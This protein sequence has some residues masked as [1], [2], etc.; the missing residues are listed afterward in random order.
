MPNLKERYAAQ[1]YV[2]VEADGE[3]FRFTGYPDD[4]ADP[5]GAFSEAFQ[6][7]V[8]VVGDVLE[9][10]E[11]LARDKRFSPTGRQ[12]KLAQFARKKAATEVENPGKGSMDDNLA[13]IDSHISRLKQ[14]IHE[15]RESLEGPPTA[16]SD[17]E[18]AR[19]AEM[20]SHLKGM[21]PSQRR[22]FLNRA[23]DERRDDVIRAALDGAPELSGLDPDH[24]EKMR[25]REIRERNPETLQEIESELKALNALET[26]E[27]KARDA[28]MAL[29]SEPVPDASEEAA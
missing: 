2:A 27:A 5:G 11:S 29:A 17:V 4:A 24:Q 19:D 26:M 15:K 16:E 23:Q 13:R 3:R 10:R 25:E 20:R 6:V 9:R 12:E 28:M 1:N 22:Q 18:V 14:S 7:T 21:D 8:G